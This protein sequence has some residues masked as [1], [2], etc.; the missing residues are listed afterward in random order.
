M[1]TGS[2]NVSS[3]EIA[4]VVSLVL[5][6]HGTDCSTP[7]DA[8]YPGDGSTALG[9]QANL[10]YIAQNMLYT[11]FA[12]FMLDW[13]DAIENLC[14]NLR[15]FN[16]EFVGFFE[17]GFK[18]HFWQ[19][20]SNRELVLLCWC[21]QLGMAVRRG[22]WANNLH[23]IPQSTCTG[24]GANDETDIDVAQI[25]GGVYNPFYLRID[26]LSYS[27]GLRSVGQMT[28]FMAP[29]LLRYI[30]EVNYETHNYAEPERGIYQEDLLTGLDII[31]DEASREF[32]MGWRSIGR[33]YMDFFTDFKTG[34]FADLRSEAARTDNTS[35]RTAWHLGFNDVTDVSGTRGTAPDNVAN[36]SWWSAFVERGGI[37]D[38]DR[39]DRLQQDLADLGSMEFLTGSKFSAGMQQNGKSTTKVYHRSDINGN[40]HSLDL[41]L[42]P[43]CKMALVNFDL[44]F[45]DLDSNNTNIRPGD[46][47]WPQVPS[48]PAVPRLTIAWP[49]SGS[50][51]HVYA[52]NALHPLCHINPGTWSTLTGDNVFGYGRGYSHVC[53]P[54]GRLPDP[55]RYNSS[56]TNTPA[57]FAVEFDS[58]DRYIMPMFGE[59]Y[60]DVGPDGWFPALM[61]RCS[62]IYERWQ[63]TQQA[64]PW[65][66]KW[67]GSAISG[68]NLVSMMS[69]STGEALIQSNLPALLHGGYC[70][71][72]NDNRWTLEARTNMR[73]LHSPVVHIRPARRQDGIVGMDAVAVLLPE[74]Q[75]VNAF[76]TGNLMLNVLMHLNGNFSL[77][78]TAAPDPLFYGAGYNNFGNH[79]HMHLHFYSDELSWDANSAG[80]LG[81]N[82]RVLY[83]GDKLLNNVVL[84]H[85]ITPLC[86]VTGSVDDAAVG[87]TREQPMFV[88]FIS[89]AP[90]DTMPT[91]VTQVFDFYD[92]AVVDDFAVVNAAHCVPGMRQWYIPFYTLDPTAVSGENNSP[93][94]MFGMGD[95][96]ELN[97][98]LLNGIMGR[99]RYSPEVVS[100]VNTFR[101]SFGVDANG[102][103]ILY[104]ERPLLTFDFG[105]DVEM[106]DSDLWMEY[107]SYR[108]G[109]EHG[110]D[111]A[112]NTLELSTLAF[113]QV[114]F[115]VLMIDQDYQDH[116][117]AAFGVTQFFAHRQTFTHST[118]HAILDKEF[119]ADYSGSMNSLG[120]G[121]GVVS[122]SSFD[123]SDVDSASTAE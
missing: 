9:A 66:S 104:P 63:E 93:C 32:G 116:F 100:V 26:D 74:G 96:D 48:W 98:S 6:D 83:H 21:V 54:D 76:L 25:W 57:T 72:N 84:N 77:N 123:T 108:R 106:W 69:L 113:K 15:Y 8:A 78:P 29:G 56:G 7:F 85:L 38:S 31:L 118:A 50:G 80:R 122:G 62:R 82:V 92:E 46:S 24:V 112:Q 5:S 71:I 68:V 51:Y 73:Q 27:T 119:N 79:S 28:E 61:K 97:G 20:L 101:N 3:Y 107:L 111:A 14:L 2:V 53:Y 65:K 110:G 19:K 88:S 81:S 33:G 87:I 64:T 41:S 40:E 90:D 37:V 115:K 99:R 30:D 4:D 35:L 103:G 89:T 16:N 11:S 121:G 120:S 102:N 23:N 109:L 105:N 44:R 86:M 94:S 95:N 75:D 67:T 60:Y 1:L 18:S 17:R 39:I 58:A 114:P 13:R 117:L 70:G 52:Q 10:N 34:E 45:N 55:A 12:D 42:D 91:Q 59:I 36:P 49:S 47:N 22:T 43:E